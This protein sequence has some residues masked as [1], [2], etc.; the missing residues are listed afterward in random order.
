MTAPCLENVVHRISHGSL[1]AT[2]L[3]RW[4]ECADPSPAELLN[5]LLSLRWTQVRHWQGVFEWAF[6]RVL[7]ELEPAAR[8]SAVVVFSLNAWLDGDPF[9]SATK[10]ISSAYAEVGLPPPEWLASIAVHAR[11]AGVPMTGDVPAE[12]WPATTPVPEGHDAEAWL[13]TWYEHRDLVRRALEDA[14]LSP[15]EA[16]RLVGEVFTRFAAAG[17]APEGSTEKAL[18]EL[19]LLVARDH[20]AR[21]A[22]APVPA[23]DPLHACR[24]PEP[25]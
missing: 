6:Q 18:R 21:L 24:P 2:E 3:E 4:A 14:G 22:V 15:S 12:A 23:S 5:Q 11:D 16:E 7:T 20:V 13:Q 25:S 9:G 8:S 17:G 19:S 10:A 1:A